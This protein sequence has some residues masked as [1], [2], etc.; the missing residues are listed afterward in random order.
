M[1]NYLSIAEAATL[2]NVTPQA[3]YI[4]IKAGKIKVCRDS[5]R[6][7]VTEEEV[8]S[9]MKN[10]GNKAFSMHNGKLK[11]DI[12][13]GKIDTKTAMELCGFDKN[14]LYNYLRRGKIS[15]EKIGAAYVI[16]KEDLLRLAQSIR[17]KRNL[18]RV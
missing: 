11:F 16:D 7:L 2:K 12:K 1:Q 9:Y 17:I 13:N 3:L 18:R 14:K 5:V 6:W 8:D 15:Y 4:A 10:R